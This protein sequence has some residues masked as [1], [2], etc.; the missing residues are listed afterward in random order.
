MHRRRLVEIPA[1]GLSLLL[2]FMDEIPDCFVSRMYMWASLK[3][4]GDQADSML[5]SA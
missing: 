4:S 3:R 2:F 5:I 1:T